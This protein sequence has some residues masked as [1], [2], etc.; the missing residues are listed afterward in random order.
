MRKYILFLV[1]AFLIIACGKGSKAGQ[2]NSSAIDTIPLMVMQIQKCSRL[3]T[4]EYQVHKIVT[5][6]DTMSVSGQF[7]SKKFKIGLPAGKR[8]I[9]IPVT[10]SIKAYIDFSKF[11]SAN[12]KK[13]GNQIEI[14]L[15]D[16][17]FTMTSTEIDHKHVKQK[18]SFFRSK[19]SDEEI[20]RIQ[21]QGRTDILRTLP[22]LGIAEN[23]RQSAARQLIPIIEQMGYRP[24]EVIITFRQDFNWNDIPSLIKS[25]E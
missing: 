19:F 16:P 8:R 21:Q 22:H 15:P 24:E 20:T 7:L 13:K 9:A 5:F 12:V 6:A 3:Y 25:I 2:E 14:I 11:S 17:Q 23:A 18:V 10:A 1:I 4:S